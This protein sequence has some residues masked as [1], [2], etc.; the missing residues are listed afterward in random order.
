M[1]TVAESNEQ[2]LWEEEAF[3][4]FVKTEVEDLFLDE[5]FLAVALV[6]FEHTKKGV[7]LSL[8]IPAYKRHGASERRTDENGTGENGRS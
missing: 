8:A 3:K 5:K 2:K 6:S 7:E 1:Q 4:L